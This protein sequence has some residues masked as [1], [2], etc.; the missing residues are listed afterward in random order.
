MTPSPSSLSPLS[1][2]TSRIFRID[3]LSV[4]MDPSL[5]NEGAIGRGDWRRTH[6]PVSSTGCSRSRGIR[7]QDRVESLLRIAW[8]ECSR[9]S[10]I[11]AQDP[12]DYAVAALLARKPD[13]AAAREGR[14]APLLDHANLRGPGYY[15]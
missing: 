8:T 13:D 10:G 7:A 4:G 11:G 15:H 12:V 5:L 14:P 9:S 3:N 1:R 6:L 2:R